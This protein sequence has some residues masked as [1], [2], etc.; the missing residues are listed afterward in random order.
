MAPTRERQD[1][2]HVSDEEQTMYDTLETRNLANILK[3]QAKVKAR[4]K[5]QGA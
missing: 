2:R 1:E 4:P 5:V 3:S